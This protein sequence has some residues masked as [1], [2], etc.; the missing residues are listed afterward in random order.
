MRLAVEVSTCS[1][2]RTGIGYYTEHLVDGLLATR[3]PSDDVVLIS[4]GKPAAELVD[5]WQRYLHTGGVPVR[6]IWM[7]RD[8]PRLLAEVGAGFAVFPNYLAPIGVRCPFVNVVHDLAIIRTPAFFNFSKLALQ[9]SL[10][11]MVVREATAVATVSQASRRDV[12]ALLGVPEE[13]ILMLPG[14]P[15]PACRPPSEAEV[16]EVRQR[17]RL[18]RPYLLSVGTLE[19]RKNL[20]TLLRAFDHL[21]ARGG[22]AAAD[23]DLVIVG[24]RGWRDREL[25][26]EIGKRLATGRVHTLGYVAERDLIGLYG[27]AVALAY[28]S[29]FEGFGL[30]VIEAMACGTA[31]VASDVE[32]LREISG[33]AAEL[34]PVGD[35]AALGDAVARLVDDPAAHAAARARGLARAAAFSWEATAERLWR[36]ARAHARTPATQP[37]PLRPFGGVAT[38]A[39]A[40]AARPPAAGPVTPSAGARVPSPTDAQVSSPADLLAADDPSW[41]VLATV[42]YADLFDAPVTAD[43]AARACLGARLSPAEVRARVARPPLEGL[44][45]LHPSGHLTLRGREPLVARQAD[46]A[47]RTAELLARHRRVISALASLPFV[48]MLALSGGTAHRNARGGDDIDLFVVASAGRA[49]T[50]YTMLFLASTLTRRRGI[51]CPNYLVDEGHLQIAYH[52]DLFTAHQAI[53]LVPLAGIEIFDRF[54]AANEAWVRDFYPAYVPRAAE[55]PLAPSPVQRLAER[56]FRWSLGDEIERVLSVAWRFHLGRRAARSPQPDLVL[57]PGILKLHLSDHRRHV[58]A[59]FEERLAGLRSLWTGPRPAA[60]APEAAVG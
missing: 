5:R 52:H 51:L 59:R 3:A 40:S 47:V 30:P 14:A 4:N 39:P 31:V 44:V 18:E 29:H 55:G 41:A 22:T 48:R 13:R 11:P 25:R 16:A 35:A 50:A 12:V 19:P 20:P 27:G 38:P 46:G 54:V 49:Y 1:A 21:L 7:Q 53:S 57:D 56:P 17:F 43:E 28:P 45:A 60:P 26:G 32:A 6:S 10:L 33:G 2:E 42:V 36:F 23:V 34:V 15:H 58:L 8:A 24:G 37:G 9:R